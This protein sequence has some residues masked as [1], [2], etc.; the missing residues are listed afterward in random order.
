MANGRPPKFKTELELWTK[1]LEYFK[2]C[3]AAPRV[4]NKAGLC[5]FLNISRDTYNE[6]KKK[7][8]D[9]IKSAQDIIQDAWVQRLAGTTPIGAIFYFK[10]AFSEDFRDRTELT[11]KDGK[12]LPIP[13]L[14]VSTH[15]RDQADSGIK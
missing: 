14:N 13:I 11:G 5:V 3:D 4:P 12:D 2:F 15:H 1:I 9:A 10:N 8:P 6:Y 7:F